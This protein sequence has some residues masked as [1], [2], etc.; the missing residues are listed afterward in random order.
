MSCSQVLSFDRRLEE[1]YKQ[2]DLPFY[3][4][5]FLVNVV[6]SLNTHMH[7]QVR[8][9]VGKGAW[10]FLLNEACRKSCTSAILMPWPSI[11]VL[12]LEEK[13]PIILITVYVLG[14]EGGE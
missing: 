8:K 1:F 2:G 5:Y 4:F 10:K 13:F 14:L 9:L 7:F 12:P 6:G 11:F 3:I